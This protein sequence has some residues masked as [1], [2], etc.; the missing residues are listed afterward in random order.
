[1]KK[2]ETGENKIKKICDELRKQTIEP[3]KNQG[4]EIIEN[5]KIEAQ[6]IINDAQKKAENLLKETFKEIEL[7]KKQGLTALKLSCRQVIDELKQRIEKGFFQKNLK[8]LVVNASNDQEIIKNLITSIILAIEKEGIESD[9]SAYISK[10]ISK[11]EINKSLLKNIL[12][13]LK[14]KEVIQGEFLSGVKI[15]LIDKDIILDISDDALMDL[16]SEYIRKDFR[17]MIFKM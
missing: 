9:L 5:A 1:M 3:A 11:K 2:M 10:N 13:K 15:K 4:K 7:K 14:E 17:E 8:D 6:N 16:I 12:D